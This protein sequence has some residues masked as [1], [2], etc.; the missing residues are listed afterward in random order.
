[1]TVVVVVPCRNEEHTVPGLLDA[2][3]AQSRPPDRIFIVNDGS[4]DGTLAAVGR[5][6][7]AHP[8]IPVSVVPGHGRGAGA[9]MNAGIAASDADVIVRLDGHCRPHPGYVEHSIATL[10][11]EAVGMTG[12]VWQIQPGASTRVARGIA[13]VLSHPLGSGGAA[14][15]QPHADGDGEV[16]AVDTVPFGTFRKS[17][18]T[19]V[20]GFDE[21]LLR[22]QDYDFAYRVGLSGLQVLLNPAIV[23]VYQARSTLSA[24]AR[25]YFD[26]GFWKV[27]MLR[28]FPAS[29]R[30]RQLLPLLLAPVVALLLIAAIAGRSRAAA[31]ALAGYAVLNAAGAA[32][33]AW[34]A[35]S[36]GLTPFAFAALLTLQNAWSAGAWMS[37]LRGARVP[38]R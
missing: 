27:I 13:A 2:V 20:G 34:R 21:S 24:L 7:R 12:G 37:L 16:R 3:A 15:R 9:A 23:S 18:W 35:G 26:Y 14:Y 32:H 28:K 33:A 30:I 17:V 6:A 11:R 31:I 8:A 25:Q 5:W 38:R 29:I 36:V 19:D 22:N 4:T 1:M 10:D